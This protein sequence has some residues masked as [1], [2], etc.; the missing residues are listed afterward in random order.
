MESECSQSKTK[1]TQNPRT[2]CKPTLLISKAG[3]W[4][5]LIKRGG[6]KT[7]S[8]QTVPSFPNC[9]TC[10][11]DCHSSQQNLT[12]QPPSSATFKHTTCR[13]HALHTLSVSTLLLILSLGVPLLCPVTFHVSATCQIWHNTKSLV[14]L[15]SIL[16]KYDDL[17]SSFFVWGP[18]VWGQ[19]AGQM[20]SAR[21][22]ACEIGYKNFQNQQGEE[23]V[24]VGLV[25]RDWEELGHRVLAVS[26]IRNYSDPEVKGG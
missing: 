8:S 13:E 20:A 22:S 26:W 10:L 12:P 1:K 25:R 4:P 24:R 6:C 9:P 18:V 15:Y 7:D 16:G 23:D 11:H 17:Q 19:V 14:F 3:T 21:G 2:T 5:A